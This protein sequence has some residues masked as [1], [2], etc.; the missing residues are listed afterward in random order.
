MLAFICNA[1]V[2]LCIVKLCCSVAQ[3]S[4]NCPH[5]PQNIMPMHCIGDI[6]LT[7]QDERVYTGGFN[8][9]CFQ[10]KGDKIYEFS[11]TV[12]LSKM[13]MDLLVRESQD[14]TSM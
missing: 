11:G 4:M 14:I 8:K 2:D 5:S 12:S 7:K 10:L 9:I 3:R 13:L 1:F 6:I